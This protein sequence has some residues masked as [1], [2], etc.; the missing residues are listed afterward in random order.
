[1]HDKFIIFVHDQK[2]QCYLKNMTI[3][4]LHSITKPKTKGH[5]Y[6]LEKLFSS[7]EIFK[8]IKHTFDYYIN[9]KLQY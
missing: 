7:A 1:M 6:G 9:I 5:C 2:S 4:N 3:E 8:H